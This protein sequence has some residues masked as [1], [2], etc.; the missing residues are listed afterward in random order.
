MKFKNK[1]NKTQVTRARDCDN[2]VQT[3]D[4]QEIWDLQNAES[5]TSWI[6][7]FL[8]KYCAETKENKIN[9]DATIVDLQV[10]KLFVSMCEQNSVIK[11]RGLMTPRDVIGTSYRDIRSAIQNQVSPKERIIAAEKA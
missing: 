4:Q 6:M 8:A 9:N 11:L 5:A 7:S 1:N 2:G 3:T 10:T